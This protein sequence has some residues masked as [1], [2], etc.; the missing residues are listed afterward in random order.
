MSISLGKDKQTVV[1]GHYGILCIIKILNY[2]QQYRLEPNWV[3]SEK[4]N[5]I[6]G[7][8]EYCVR[9]YKR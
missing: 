6:I 7:R 8:I 2:I 9:K 4:S 5:N 1:E 3:L